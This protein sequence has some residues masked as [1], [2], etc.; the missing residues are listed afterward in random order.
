MD[1]PHDDDSLDCLIFRYTDTDT[2][3]IRDGVLIPFVVN[4]RDTR[5]RI[6][7]NAFGALKEYHRGHGCGD[8]ITHGSSNFS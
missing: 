7:G 2:D 6:T 3:A 1:E 8:S 4:Q 5:H